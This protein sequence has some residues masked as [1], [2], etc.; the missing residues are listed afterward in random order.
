MLLVESSA[1]LV[2]SPALSFTQMIAY[3]LAPRRSRM[4]VSTIS[5]IALYLVGRN[6]I[7]INEE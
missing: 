5:F 4:Y 2:D 6:V 3:F 1:L 7:K